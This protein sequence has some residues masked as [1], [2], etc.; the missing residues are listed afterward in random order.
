MLYTTCLAYLEDIIVFGRGFIEMLCRLDT[1][2]ELLDQANLKLKPSKCA[3]GKTS[4]SFLGHVISDRGIS[5]DPEKLRRIQEW[6][7]PHNEDETRRFLGYATYYLKF[8]KDFANIV[9]PLNKILQ[10]GRQFYWS[11]DCKVVQ[12]D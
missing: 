12:D 6:P 2:L 10:K 1:A 3:F 7:R 8:I 9:E 11:P 5:T 4:V